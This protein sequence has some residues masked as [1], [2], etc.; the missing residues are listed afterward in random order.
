MGTVVISCEVG[1]RHGRVQWTK[2]GLTLGY[3][4]SL[5]GFPRYTVLGHD[6]NG[7]FNLQIV[8]ATVNDDAIYE[9][10]VGPAPNSKPIR[11]SSKLDVLLPP[12]RIEIDGVLSGSNLRVKEHEEVELRCTVYDARPKAKIIWYRQNSE[13]YTANRQDEDRPSA[14][15]GDEGRITSISIIRFSPTNMDNGITW[16]CEAQHS[17]ITYA[18]L[19]SSVVLSVLHPPGPPEITGYIEGET[20]RLG[21]PVTLNCISSGG[22]PL[23]NI[24]WYRNGILVDTSHTASGSESRNTYPFLAS[25][26][27]NNAHFR[28]EA[29]NELSAKPMATEIVLSVQ[30]APNSLDLRGP[31]EA[32]IGE[33]ITYTCSTANSNPPATI[34]WIVGN[35]TRQAD[36]TY[37]VTSPSG[38]WITHSNITVSLGPSD[39][40]KMIICNGLNSELNDI[41]SESRMLSVIYPPGTPKIQGLGDE[42]VLTAGVLKRVTCTSLAGNP[43]ATLKWFLNDRPLESFDSTKDNYASAELEFVPRNADNGASLRCEASNAA[44][45]DPLSATKHVKVQFSPKFVKIALDPEH[46]QSG[47]NVTLSC[48]TDNSY[49]ASELAWWHNGER[50]QSATDMV[51]DGD[52]GGYITTSYL[53]LSLTAQHDGAVVTCE[54]SN[55]AVQNRVHD[56]ITLSVAHKPVFI[57]ESNEPFRVIEGQSATINMTAIANPS[58]L[59]YEWTRVDNEVENTEILSARVALQ[60][61][62]VF[63]IARVERN[64]GGY[65]TVTAKNQEGTTQAKIEIEVLY[66]PSIVNIT[67]RVLVGPGEPA[68]LECAVDAMPLGSKTIRW[69]R[70]NYDLAS[71]TKTTMG[72]P[73]TTL[74]GNA[75]SNIG[76]VLLTV[77]NATAEDSGMFWCVADNGIDN[78]EGTPRV[79]NGSLLMVRHKPIMIENPVIS[80]AAADIKDTGHLIC[81]ARGVPNVTFSWMRVGGAYIVPSNPRAPEKKFSMTESMID[82]LTWRSELFIFNV[83]NNDYGAYEC[84]ARNTEGVSRHRVPLDVKSRPDPPSSL[85]IVNVTHES[86]SLVWTP[87]F[88]GGMEQYFRIKY[89]EPD[90]SNNP[91]FH[92]VY[93]ANTH[94]V[95]LVGLRPGKQYSMAVMAFNNLGESNYSMNPILVRTTTL[96]ERLNH[97]ESAMAIQPHQTNDPEAA[98]NHE[99]GDSSGGYAS[100]VE[101]SFSITAALLGLI[102]AVISTVILVIAIAPLCRYKARDWAV[103]ATGIGS[104]PNSATTQRLVGSTSTGSTKSAQMELYTT[105]SVYNETMS[106]GET[107]SSISEK[108]CISGPNNQHG[109]MTK[110]TLGNNINDCQQQTAFMDDCMGT[111][112]FNGYLMDHPMQRSMTSDQIHTIYGNLPSVTMT[113]PLV[114]NPYVHRGLPSSATVDG[115]MSQLGSHGHNSNDDTMMAEEDDVMALYSV[116]NKQPMRHHPMDTLGFHRPLVQASPQTMPRL[117]APHQVSGNPNYEDTES[118]YAVELRR[119]AYL[120]SLAGDQGGY[121]SQMSG[122]SSSGNSSLPPPPQ[123]MQPGIP[124]N[125]FYPVPTTG[126]YAPS[127]NPHMTPPTSVVEGPLCASSPKRTVSAFT[128]FGQHQNGISNVPRFSSTGSST[129]SG[130]PAPQHPNPT[131]IPAS[132][133]LV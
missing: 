129:S 100:N 99:I 11:A 88:H 46:P 133:H 91:R 5:P 38:G 81:E 60:K 74:D 18:P 65:Y 90:Y 58:A 128:T 6:S 109:I 62:G 24:S 71:R 123:L 87:G 39:R 59:T 118:E 106:G 1:N 42:D 95:K 111:H 83:S 121:G 27:D 64:D 26:E 23:A 69:E 114:N 17:A 77:L 29:H 28:C 10:Q 61:D 63:K 79:R 112:N 53:Q 49:P 34:Q 108:S 48:E 13:F 45:T 55:P 126:P 113:N 76:V 131:P 41:K 15:G 84:V 32:K 50:L 78:D 56:A 33:I 75:N 119:Q 54:A 51:L 14:L 104:V 73:A 94:Q 93:P 35:K 96:P 80:K 40:N 36:H 19:R 102:I 117:L 68:H 86:V 52:F 30:F 20:K 12:T 116:V 110:A 3:D 105:S 130:S 124:P 25:T 44:L 66:P 127:P 97:N 115:G 125:N 37:S 2:D 103:A 101:S 21:Q 31:T 92:D 67:H 82:P 8:N 22:N 16:A 98:S 85:Q 132:G 122:A 120:Q 70:D 89:H 107:L 43:L 47:M 57:R 4:R 9:C 72:S 7:K